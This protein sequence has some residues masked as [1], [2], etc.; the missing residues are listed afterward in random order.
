MNQAHGVEWRQEKVIPRRSILAGG[1]RKRPGYDQRTE[2]LLESF[3]A[4]DVGEPQA[5]DDVSSVLYQT[6]VVKG[7]IKELNSESQAKEGMEEQRT[8]II[9]PQLNLVQR[10]AGFLEGV[11]SDGQHSLDCFCQNVE[12]SSSSPYGSAGSRRWVV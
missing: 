5:S 8:G 4:F 3:I 1:E 9:L 12:N 7:P 10:D 11:E 6:S 2:L